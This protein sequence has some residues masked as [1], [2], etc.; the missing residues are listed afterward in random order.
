M[1]DI[2][3]L[4]KKHGATISEENKEAFN[5]EFRKTY[6]S[7]GETA[8]LREQRDALKSQLKEAND[9]I[10]SFKGMDIEGVKAKAEE[11]KQK[12]EAEQAA[13]E[14]KLNALKFDYAI[15]SALGAAKAKNVKAA[16]A[17]LN[18]EALK[19]T[20]DGVVGLNEQLEKI[21]EENAFLFEDS[22]PKRRYVDSTPGAQLQT[23]DKKDEVNAALR[24]L[25]GKE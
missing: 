9:Q 10:E 3:E 6:K 2:F 4:L 13:S 25:Y 1:L 18:T 20:D 21:K 14:Q 16:R 24:Q 19:L 15:E 11:Y 17:L 23:G 7:E 22:E 8:A 12:Y 5:K